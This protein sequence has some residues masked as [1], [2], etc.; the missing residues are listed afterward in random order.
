VSFVVQQQSRLSGQHERGG[1]QREWW[2]RFVEFGANRSPSNEARVVAEV[3]GITEEQ[4]TLAWEEAVCLTI[5][6]SSGVGVQAM[7]PSTPRP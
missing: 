4:S 1:L 3:K 5:Q 6:C 7:P 2:R